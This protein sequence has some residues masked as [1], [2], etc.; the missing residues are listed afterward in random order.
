[1]LAIAGDYAA[2]DGWVERL[3]RTGP[4]PGQAHHGVGMQLVAQDQLDRAV[5]HL[6]MSLE[7]G[8]RSPD[9][10]EVWLRLGRAATR[11]GGPAS[12]EPLFRRATQLAPE[13]ASA[14]PAGT[15]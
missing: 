12:A 6:R 10:A 3:E 8:Y 4:Q 7:R 2:A 1:M 13:Q 15:A 9:E 5:P 14:A 11:A